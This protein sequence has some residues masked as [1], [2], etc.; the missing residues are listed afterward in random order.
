MLL[1][2]LVSGSV[3]DIA[4]LATEV[5]RDVVIHTKGCTL[6][7]VAADTLDCSGIAIRAVFLSLDGGNHFETLLTPDSGE[8]C[9]KEDSDPMFF[10]ILS[11]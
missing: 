5:A 11:E 9:K 10:V 4:F 1:R 6:P 7:V 2:P 3:F 8:S